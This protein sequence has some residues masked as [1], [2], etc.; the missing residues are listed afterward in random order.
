MID[1][2]QICNIIEG[3]TI[4]E[5]KITRFKEWKDLSFRFDGDNSQRDESRYVKFSMETFF[6]SLQLGK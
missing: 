4:V 1:L 6:V 3:Y 2:R 5:Y